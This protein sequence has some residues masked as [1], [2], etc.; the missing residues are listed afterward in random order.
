MSLINYFFPK[1]IHLGDT[2]FNRNISVNIWGGEPTIIV[3][4]LI[5]SGSIMTHIWKSGIHQLIPKSYTP[6]KI[7][8]LGLAAGSNAI[9][10]NKLYPKAKI[11]AVEIDPDMVEIGKKYG[12]LNQVKNLQII[13]DDAEDFAQKNQEKFDI[14]LVDCFVGKEIPVRL[15]SLTFIENLKNNCRFVLINRLWYQ[16]TKNVSQKFL[17]KLNTKFLALK[18]HTGTNIIISLVA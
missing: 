18:A 7:L 12:R 15:E 13:T 5:E 4:G 3:D 11:T 14:C 8:L 16:E 17:N 2:K 6:K 10:I 9:L 1:V